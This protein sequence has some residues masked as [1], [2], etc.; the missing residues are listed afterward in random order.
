MKILYQWALKT[1]TG[2]QEIDSSQWHT[3]PKRPLPKKG[4]IGGLS[5]TKGWLR[6]VNVQGITTEGYDHIA[7]EPITIGLDDGVKLT[8]WNDD[9]DDAI[10]DG[11]EDWVNEPQAIVWTILPLAPDPKLGMAIN[12]RQSCVRYAS[13][14]RYERLLAHP[15]QNT[16]VRPWSEF[17]PPAEEI[18]RHGVWLET[19]KLQE[20]IAKAPQSQF[21][22]MHWVDHLPPS[23]T[24]I[25]DGV[26]KL[27]EQ[28]AQGRYKQAEHTITYYQRSTARANANVASLVENALELTTAGSA[29]ATATLD[30]STNVDAFSF[31]T[32]A[33][34]PNSADWPSGTFHAQLNVNAASTGVTYLLGAAS[35]SKAYTRLDSFSI[36]LLGGFDGDSRSSPFSGTGLKLD[37]SGTQDQAA[38]S[39][40][41]L[42]CIRVRASG[43]SHGD[44]LTLTLN[45]TDSYADGPW[46]TGPDP[47]LPSVND[48]V[49]VTEDV[50]LNPSIPL[51]SE[52]VTVTDVPTILIPTLVPSINDTVTVNEGIQLDVHPLPKPF[53]AI[54]VT[55]SVSAAV[56]N[57][58][59][60]SDSVTVEDLPGYY[61]DQVWVTENTS[62][63]VTVKPSVSD[64]V[65]VTD[66][67]TIVVPT[68]VPSVSDTVTVTD[69]PT[70]Q[71]R[72]TPSV[73][74]AITVS[75]AIQISYSLPSP[76]VD[77]VSVAEDVQLN[78]TGGTPATLII[79][80][81]DSVTVLEA[82]Q[83]SYS[84]PSPVVDSVTVTE[85]VTL[86]VK[87]FPSVND[88]VTVSESV[89]L[90]VTSYPSVNDAI[91][92]TEG[93]TVRITSYVSVNDAITLVDAPTVTIP[94]LVPSVFDSVTLTDV[95]IV[96]VRVTPSVFDS[97]TVSESITLLVTSYPSVNDSVTV[98]DVP[99]LVIPTLHLSVSDAVSVV[100]APT[101]FIP[102]LTLLVNDT[103]TVAES[104]SVVRQGGGSNV[105]VDDSITVTDVPTLLIPTL[106]L[107]VSENISVS[108]SVD[109]LFRQLNVSVS[110][111]VQVTESTTIS[112]KG[113]HWED[114]H[115]TSYILED[116]H[117]SSYSHSSKHST[118][119]VN[120]DKH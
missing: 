25:V 14:E 34:Q 68:L 55:E 49:T 40:S 103:I 51:I 95:P 43:D 15:P 47:N 23:E 70:V 116:K 12:T 1:P 36:N 117:N 111:L 80:V 57:N 112:N 75:E 37:T 31:L 39:A 77:S 102:T 104:V 79:S 21:G 45:T 76:I 105:S 50:R 22:W 60:V 98:S 73:F 18:T 91:T 38:G 78:I 114:K 85:A 4:E 58:I 94:T 81:F 26:R 2:W 48:T 16:T 59:S 106:I 86:L 115:S 113:Y 119:Y 109:L 120:E 27:K 107:S 6:N 46:T 87:S 9:P 54:T 7:I 89:T 13:G 67:P 72:V 11:V 53:D 30:S 66:V 44:V 10:V 88:A 8:V 108:E 64:T 32:P 33:N 101:V 82:V 17:V 28:R 56:I 118:S 20:H 110:D 41:D 99:T 96:Q 3:L 97:I 92:I 63:Q 62:L 90:L 69:V 84:V 35:L 24:E 5:N 52:A 71:V 29:T 19:P 83:V 93:I 61:P 100:D 65:T 42:F 74:D